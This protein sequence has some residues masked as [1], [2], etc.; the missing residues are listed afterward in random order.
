MTYPRVATLKTAADFRAR[1]D[2]LGVL[3]P[4]DEHLVTG[5]DAPLAK[6]YDRKA[7]MVGNRFAI[8]PM[9]DGDNGEHRSS[10]VWTEDAQLAH[11]LLELDAARF[12]AEFARRFGE[13]LGRK[14]PETCLE[15]RSAV[16]G[17]LVCRAEP[18]RH[19]LPCQR[20]F[21]GKAFRRKDAAQHPPRV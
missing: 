10:I 17:Q 8:L 12:Q 13:H 5:P 2:A 7:G 11:R 14:Q 16:I 20:I 9:R 21:L 3:L 15:Q 1:L 19:V 4:F 6:P 18:R